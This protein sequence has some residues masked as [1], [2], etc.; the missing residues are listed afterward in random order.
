MKHNN[1]TIYHQFLAVLALLL[2]AAPGTRAQGQ[3][4]TARP[5][6]LPLVGTT[7]GPTSEP[8]LNVLIS[9][10]IQ[11]HGQV[12]G[13]QLNV[14]YNPLDVCP[15]AVD[16]ATHGIQSQPYQF[17]FESNCDGKIW[18]YT[19]PCN[20][21]PNFIWTIK[22]F[23]EGGGEYQE[24]WQDM[25]YGDFSKVRL[26]LY[27]RVPYPS[28][29][30]SAPTPTS[31]DATQAG[32]GNTKFSAMPYP[33]LYCLNAPA[34]AVQPGDVITSV[35][36]ECTGYSC[37]WS[38]GQDD[39]AITI[40]YYGRQP[41]AIA[42]NGPTP[43]CR[44]T[45]YP[46]SVSSVFAATNYVWDSSGLNGAVISGVNGTN[47]NLDVSG[48]PAGTNSIT[49]RVAAQD[50]AHCGGITS[51]TRELVVPIQQAPA[52]PTS[53]QL[54]GGR[55]PA[56][57]EKTLRVTATTSSSIAKYRWQLV[58]A[59]N[60][61]GTYLVGN[62][63]TQITAPN[64]PIEGTTV[65]QQI[66]TP[67]A[68]TVTVSVE[69]KADECGGYGPA[70]TQSFQIGN[71]ALATPSGYTGPGSWC[72]TNANRITIAA[73]PG[74]EYYP[75]NF[76]GA[77]AQNIQPAGA[78]VGASQAVGGS[79]DF[80]IS[81]GTNSAGQFPTSFDLYVNVI[82][83]C[84]GGGAA[85]QV[86]LLPVAVGAVRKCGRVGGRSSGADAAEPVGLYPN[87]TKGVVSIEARPNVRYEWVKVTDAQGRVVTQRHRSDEAGITM[88]D[89]KAMPT[90]L[91]QVQLFD[92]QRLTTQR[93]LKE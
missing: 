25:T 31:G 69:T 42:V 71:V 66:G 92:G 19:D 12:G 34:N 74:L 44:N 64:T 78:Q 37:G 70:L 55:C 87:P 79:P 93:L 35:R 46:I 17:E 84:P 54:D 8:A 81:I 15:N 75:L 23:T 20:A 56:T 77:Y 10:K 53:L 65:T 72:W 28:G 13:T 5:G 47:A 41:G 62:G 91:Y 48:V 83:P 80:D 90:G 82:S 38:G 60:P 51:A 76:F 63:N 68:G 24:K 43:L 86:Y 3:S 59:N 49:L 58:G 21:K 61:P 18:L 67:N 57:T 2:L 9:N 73:T 22:Y 50:N 14:R 32:G 16:P 36:L 6:N 39:D 1:S 26:Y 52:Q 89:L 4:N 45:T 40:R 7:T 33:N 85:S 30:S 88:F 27:D 11:F 29:G